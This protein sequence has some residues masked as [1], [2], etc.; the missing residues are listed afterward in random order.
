MNILIVDDEAPARFALRRAL[1]QSNYRILEAA[2]GQ[3]ALQVIRSEHPDL[4]FLDLQ[5]PGLGGLEV[6]RQWGSQI[7]SVEI[8]VLTA[9][10]NVAAAVECIRLGAS[11]FVTKPYEVEQ[12]RAIARRVAQ[13]LMLQQQVADLQGQLELQQA[14]G[15]LIGVSR[16]MRR[17]YEQMKKAARS[18]S[19]LLIRGETGTGK[20]LIAREMHRLSDRAG[21]PFVAVNTAAIP[22]SLTESEL[23]GHVRGAFT[24]ADSNRTGVFEQADGGTLFLDEIGDMPLAAQTKMLRV[25]QER[26][27]QPV[28]APRTLPVNVRIIS[29]T[30]QDLESAMADGGFRADLFYRLKGVELHVP[31]LRSRR[32]DILVLAHHFLER[33]A[34]DTGTQR[35]ELTSDSVDV[36]L[37]H[38]WPGNV[39]ELEQSIQRAT[40]M[41]DGNCI[42]PADLGLS[43]NAL[44]HDENPF[45]QYIG[46]PL[47]EA[48]NLVVE[49]LE[50]SLIT[51][52]LDRA[53]G[54]I[55]EAARQLGMHRQSL[56]QKL[57]QLGIRNR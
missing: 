28:G 29:A 42:R 35:P 36:L 41:C 32:E 4:V 18:S 45:S 44:T 9:S 53:A 52:A 37:T 21:G 55:S 49:A 47:T 31:P 23:F 7:P 19:D 51:S 3:T 33:C 50:R 14:C 2:D 8:I 46:L 16:P 25:L 30:H 15:S 6:L 26:V 27:I 56:Q 39:R 20:E 54:N 43:H 5:M 10:D 12:V 38:S 57:A 48:R 34:M 40:T 1:T 24:G 17:L 22:E 13:R 11:D